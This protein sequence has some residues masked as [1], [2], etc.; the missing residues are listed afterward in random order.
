[1][2]RT[3]AERGVENLLLGCARA[4]PGERLLIATEPADLGYFDAR[5]AP[6]VAAT[7]RELGLGVDV[8]DVGFE[9][10]TPTLSDA[11]LARIEEADIVLFLARLGDQLRFSDMPAGKRIVVSFALREELLASPF[12]T[13]D[14][15][16][17]LEIKAAV[18][19]ALAQAREVRLTCPAGTDVAGRPQIPQGVDGDTTVRRF[20]MSVF[21]PVPAQGFSGRVALRFLTGTGSRYY[22]GQML[23]FEAPVFALLEDGRLTG[24]EGAAHDV[25]R[26]E[27]QY[28]RVAGMFGIDRDAVHSWHAGIHP[29][30]GFYWDIHENADRWAGAAFG[31]PRI[32]HFHTCGAYAPGEICWN[33]FDPTI[34]VDGMALWERGVLRADRLPGGAGILSRHPDAAALFTAPDPEIGVALPWQ[35]TSAGQD[36]G[37]GLDT[38]ASDA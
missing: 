37:R 5:V 24:F 35:P 21:T 1:M 32:L 36:C 22:E 9:P 12:G 31:N 7:A 6:C 28:D 4:Q 26:A 2:A 29:G 20:P 14:Y 34:E 16:T 18:D 27:A 19:A 11:L 38:A 17:F 10:R 13:T 23:D 25:A 8:V 15:A 33:V 3:A 30:C